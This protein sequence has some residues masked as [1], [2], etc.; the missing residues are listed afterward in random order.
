MRFAMGAPG[1]AGTAMTRT[2]VDY[3]WEN[4]AGTS[5]AAGAGIPAPGALALLGVA[6]LAGARRRR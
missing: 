3:A 4:V 2:V 1:S 6:G 5:I